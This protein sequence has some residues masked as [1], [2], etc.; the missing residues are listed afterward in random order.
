MKTHIKKK[1]RTCVD[2]RV[3]KKNRGERCNETTTTT[4][5]LR[6]NIQSRTMFIT[7]VK[8]TK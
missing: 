4:K 6:R 3:K 8:K 2:E 7:T 5:N 1:N